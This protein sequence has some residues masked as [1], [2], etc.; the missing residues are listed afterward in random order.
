M[1]Q[2][3][4]VQADDIGVELDEFLCRVYPLL[5]KRDLRALVRDGSVTVN[6]MPSSPSQRLRADDVVLCDFDE[7]DLAETPAPVAPSEPPKLLYEDAHVLVIDKPADLLV[8]PDRWEEQRPNLLGGLHEFS[9]LRGERGEAEFRPRLVHRLDKDTSGCIVVAKTVDAERVLGQAFETGGVRKRY[10]ALVEGE[11]PMGADESETLDLPIGPDLRRSG[12]MCVRRDGKP[13]QTV[14]RVRERFR[15]FTL[16]ECEPLT[17]RTH[18][19]RVHLAAQGFPLVVDSLYGRRKAL[20]LSE[21]KSSYRR[22]PGSAETPLIARLTLHAE[23]LEFPR[24]TAEAAQPDAAPQWIQAHSP[25][26]KDLERTLKQLA[27]WRPAR[28]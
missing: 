1:N 11:H 14:V 19:I 9:R 24:V 17:G 28:R 5:R 21:I 6:G 13:A 4:C 20:L 2:N 27:K 25:A 15:G 7:E 12:H 23:H 3:F 26:P 8:E 18:Q 22:K 10:L 16:L